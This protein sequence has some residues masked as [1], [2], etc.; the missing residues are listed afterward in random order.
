MFLLMSSTFFCWT[1][2]FGVKKMKPI[3]CR[4]FPFAEQPQVP[5]YEE[6]G[7][8]LPQKSLAG[9]AC[10]GPVLSNCHQLTFTSRTALP[11]LAPQAPAP[12]SSLTSDKETGKESPGL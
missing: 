1:L 12:W 8:L 2:D 11:D 6:L 4:Q 5:L 9:G 3:N 10:S 7:L